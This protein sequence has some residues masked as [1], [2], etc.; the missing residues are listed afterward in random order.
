MY[1]RVYHEETLLTIGCKVSCEKVNIVCT[2]YINFSHFFIAYPQAAGAFWSSERKKMYINIQVSLSIPRKES[3]VQGIM[4]STARS[5]RG[6]KVSP[7]L[8]M[9]CV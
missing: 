3:V 9:V 7:A 1:S 2:L 8:A 5:V 6:Q 4:A